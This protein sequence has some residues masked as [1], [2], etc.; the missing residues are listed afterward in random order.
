M[1]LAARLA[2]GGHPSGCAR[3]GNTVAC[4]CVDGKAMGVMRLLVVSG[5]SSNSMVRPPHLVNGN[6]AKT[7]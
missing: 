4:G 7:M 6:L 1:V 5:S 2:E 3:P